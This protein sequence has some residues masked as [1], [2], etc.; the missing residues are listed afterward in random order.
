MQPMRA[1]MHVMKT[2][3]MKTN[4]FLFL[5]LL[6]SPLYSAEEGNMENASS[7]SSSQEGYTINYQT[8][9]ILEYLRFASKICKINFIYEETDLNFNVTI[10]SDE[11]ITAK[12]VMA[13]LVQ[14]LRIH[15]L[16]LLEQDNSLVIH[17][18]ADVKQMATLVTETQKDGMS[19]IVTRIFRIKNANPDSVATIIRPM[20]STSALLEVSPETRQLI[21]TDITANVDKVAMLIENLDSPYSILDIKT[22][23]AKHLSTL[24]LVDLA[25]QIMSPIAFGNPFLL[26]P[27]DL[28][29]KIFIVSTPEL[30]ERALNVLTTLDTPPKKEIADARKL[31]NENI[32]VYKV[33]HRSGSD[34]LQGLKSIASNLE[35][36]GMPDPD[37]IDTIDSAKWIRESNSIM[38]VGSKDSV[39]KVKEF[40]TSLDVTPSQGQAS[41]FVYKPQFKSAQ[42]V[43]KAIREMADNLHGSKGADQ[44]LI[45]TIESVKVNPLTQTL[46]FSGEEGTFP[47]VK[48]LLSTIDSGKLKQAVKNDFYV[49]KIQQSPAEELVSSLKDF[50]K[51]LDKT[52]AA[53]DGLIQTIDRVKYI[54]ETNSLLFTGP[55]TALKKLQE[56]VPSFDTGIAKVPSNSQF[57]IYKPVYRKGDQLL[58]SMKDVVE[59]LK[60][61]KLSDPALIRSLESAK[62]VKSTNS[63]IFTGDPESLK[64]IE[65]LM[66]TLDI[67]A[68]PGS[69]KSFFLYQPLYASKEK[70]EAYVNQVADNLAK[71]NEDDLVDALRSMKWIEPS[72]SF[73]FNG[74][75]DSL[76]RVQDLLKT[77]DTPEK[78]QTPTFTIYHLQYAPQD[79][80]E[81]Y[82]NQVAE[83]LSK[84]RGSEDLVTAI[85]SMKWIPESHSFIFNGNAPALTQIKDLLQNYDTPEAAK[86]ITKSGYYIYKLQN[87]SGDV[88][89]EDLDNLA[90]NFKSSGLKD[91]NIPDVIEKMRY[92]KE[93]N[94]LLLTGD[95]QAIDEVKKL[96]ADYDYPRSAGPVNSNFYMYKPQHLKAPQIEKSLRDVATNLKN[97]NLADPALLH[98]LDTAKYVETTNSLVFTGPPDTLQKIQTLIK[99]IDVPPEKHAPIQHVG[100]TTFLLYKLKNASGNQIVTSLKAMT[101]N[102]KKSGTS[103]KDFIAALNSMK[104]VKETNSL[105]FTGTDEAL[106]RVQTLVEQF[107]VTG[108]APKVEAP[109]SG[110]GNFFVYKPQSLSGPDI[111]KLMQD[112][113]DNLRS[114]GLN[115]PD[116]F[117]AITSMRYVEKTQSI[118][119]TGTPKALDQIKELLKS[120]DI[121]SNLPEGPTPGGPLEPTIQAIDNTSFLVYKLQFHKGDEIQ[122]AL[123][124]IA[125]DLILSSAPVNQNLLNSIN[126]IQWLEVTNSLLSSGDQETLTRLRELIKNLDIP[127]KQVFIEMLVLQT[128]L[129]NALTFGLEWGANYKYRNKFSGNTFLTN[130][131]TSVSTNGCSPDTF[132]KNLANIGPT[133]NSTSSNTPTPQLIPQGCGFDMGVIGE[134][135]RHNGGTFLSLG[136]LL[137]ALQTDAEATIIMTPKLITQDGRTS[138][139]FVGENIPFA[140]SFVQNS[141]G[142]GTL[143]TS[144]IEY[145]DIGFNLTITPVLGNSDIVTLDIS[146]DRTQTLTDITQASLTPTNLTANGIITSKTSMETTVHVPDNNFLILSGMVNNSKQ[147]SNAGLPCLGGLPVIGAA[148][149]SASDTISNSNIVIFIRPHIIN[150]LDDMRRIT[151]HEEDYFRDQAGTPYLEHNYDDSIE[152]LKT[153]DDE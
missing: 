26:V 113:A 104:Y 61:D 72:H 24:G 57:F 45:E 54:K 144:N 112:F 51:N 53:E 118:I 52:N 124:Q 21:L 46:V 66:S 122:G 136:S 60:H 41:F 56:L 111:E 99:D 141:N 130:P 76:A 78:A 146:L 123:K 149:S 23:E 27:Q 147:K 110:P 115:D 96:I 55:D 83:N 59:H 116:L 84:K 36:S 19:P 91:T 31:K 1:E 148:F 74:T 151:A 119:F 97:A 94:S 125:K 152:L 7:S 62:W 79:K 2:S 11:P 22:Y 85:R 29:N 37:L 140:G 38:L 43:E 117:N 13:T 139:I 101:S 153:V 6:I 63:L 102:L 106:G 58:T 67:T 12:N 128:T 18:S 17:K 39:D 133:G 65:T 14:I 69:A 32:Y 44:S 35:S 75:K 34:I 86:K 20:I 50:A 95:P 142:G 127:L 81:E 131:G 10:V 105:L 9:S 108:L 120:F 90:K 15:G 3:W 129:S 92:V 28:T 30:T 89:E 48:E 132:V 49:Y 42:E 64:K 135:I 5:L 137:Q 16:M 25:V 40:L 88:V 126:S 134:V 145:R 109:P 77:F 73:M 68:S 4:L 98:T 80:A 121:P 93:T 87:T 33:L 138:S 114:S 71:R 47:Q 150:S 70:T 82:L 100:K 103:D 107:D 143:S 8:V